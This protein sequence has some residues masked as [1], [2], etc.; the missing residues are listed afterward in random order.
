[1]TSSEDPK[2][3]SVKQDLR[4]EVTLGSGLEAA[5]DTFTTDDDEVGNDELVA[6]Q[7]A[8]MSELAAPPFEVE[9]QRQRLRVGGTA[10]VVFFG[11]LLC[12]E[13]VFLVEV[14]PRGTTTPDWNEYSL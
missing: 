1:M 2:S 7:V 3:S 12:L 8:M 9:V 11:R 13:A 10:S 14:P 5:E 4:S 6:A